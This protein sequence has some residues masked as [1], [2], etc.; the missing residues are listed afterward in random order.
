MPK[1]QTSRDRFVATAARL[2]M[3]QGYHG[4]GLSQIVS[5][6]GAPKG[7]LYFYFPQG[8]EQLAAAS[9]E[10]AGSVF[11]SQLKL[12]LANEPIPAAALGNLC[13]LLAQW[14]T[15]SDFNEGCPITNA[16]LELAPGNA[17]VTVACDAI[18]S[19]WRAEWERHLIT[20]GWAA[21]AAPAI[22]TTIVSAVEGAFILARASRSILPF[23][24]VSGALTKMLNANLH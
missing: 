23:T 1:Q 8:K 5:E 24:H 15:Q 17:A 6:S 13:D 21:H 10:K 7:S 22:A 20:A 19:E 4:T 12:V 16:C 3:R 18:F 2:F 11:A 9:V 14:M